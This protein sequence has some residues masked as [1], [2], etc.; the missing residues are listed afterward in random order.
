MMMPA[1][2]GE[3]ASQHLRRSAQGML[4]SSAWAARLRS[5]NWPATLWTG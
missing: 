2:D 4:P 3:Q 5:Q 1:P